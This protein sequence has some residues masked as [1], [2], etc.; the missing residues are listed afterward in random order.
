MERIKIKPRHNYIKKLEKISFNFHST[1]GLYWDESAYYKFNLFEINE[2]EEATNKLYE[3]CLTAVQHVIDNDLFDKLNIN[4]NL[5]PLILRSWENDE[6][7]IYGRFDLAYDGLRPPKMLEFN[8]DTPGTL[9]ESSIVQHK[10]LEDVSIRDKQFNSIQ[11]KLMGYWYRLLDYLKGETLHFT[12]VDS[13]EDVT[14]TK[15]LMDTATK[16]GIATKYI[17]IQDIGWDDKNNEF[18]GLNNETIFN[19]FK[20][21]PWEWLIQENFGMNIVKDSAESKWIEPAWKVILSSKGI[22]AILWELFPHNQYLLP[23]YFDD[24]H[25]MYNYVKKPFFSREGANITIFRNGIQ[26]TTVDG[27][28]DEEEYVYQELFELPNWDG[29]FPVIGSWVIGNESCGIGIRENNLE[30]TDNSSRFIPHLI[31][32]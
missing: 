14:I 3:M 26:T 6:P 2:I 17:G 31:K 29:N 5:I 9:Y 19:I 24:P 18:V 27:E 11:E 32:I 23:A 12:S 4:R 25:D 22:L 16:A 13:D 7:S 15:Y 8:G 20:L 28:Y 1:N 21:Y 30:I 10:W